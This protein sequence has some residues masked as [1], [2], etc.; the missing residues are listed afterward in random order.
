MAITVFQIDKSGG[1]IFE[2]DYSIVLILNKKE[3]YGVNIPK[4][5]K[6]ELVNLFKKGELNIN[7][8][9]KKK[10]K[11][12]FRLRFHTIVV[13]KLIEKALYDLGSI[14]EV[15]MLI[16]NDFD[17]HFHEIQ[18]MIFKN[19]FKLIPSLKLEDIIQ[20]KFQKPSLIDDAGKAFRNNDKDKL[21]DYN[22]VKLNLIELIK[23]IK[24]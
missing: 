6:D 17:G 4:K 22:L 23:I 18:D 16:C 9:S 13:I 3:V 19:I 10:R 12:R 11:N 20:T 7:H 21:K 15:N 14:D 1:D 2:K 24:K 5:I 8:N